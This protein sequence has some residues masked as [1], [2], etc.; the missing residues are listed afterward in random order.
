MKR[1]LLTTA[2][3]GLIAGSASAAP[4]A[5]GSEISL[6]G[7]DTFTATSVSFLNPANVGSSTLSGSFTILSGCTGCATMTNLST[8]SVLPQLL[9][10]LTEGTGASAIHSTLTVSDDNF[11]FTP[12]TPLNSLNV[13]GH[14]TLTLTGFD[15]TPGAFLL[16]TQGPG[17]TVDV[18][19]SVTSEA[20]APEP[21][22]IAL[23]GVGLLGLGVVTSR[24]RRA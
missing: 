14:G 1:F 13:T 4:I 5:A 3:L 8:L 15:P 7:S 24:K 9:Y 20:L 19:F 12:G 17:G 10:T 18:T 23:L 11:A 21:A 16:T 22:S 6:D 2:A